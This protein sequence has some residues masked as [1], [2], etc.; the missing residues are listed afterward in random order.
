MLDLAEAEGCT[1]S[2]AL[3]EAMHDWVGKRRRQR[4]A[5]DV[6]EAGASRTA[7]S[8]GGWRFRL[9]W[10]VRGLSRVGRRVIMVMSAQFRC[11]SECWGSRS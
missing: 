11:A 5:D 3:I 6:P 10:L 9:H 7:Q 1:P 8:S 2:D 4:G